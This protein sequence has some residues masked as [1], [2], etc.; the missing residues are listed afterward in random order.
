MQGGKVM[1]EE[2]L[3]IV[4]ERRKAK[5]K[6]GKRK[7]NAEFQRQQGKRR[8]PS[9]NKQTNKK[10]CKETKESNRIGKTR[11]LFKKR[12]IKGIFHMRVG[13]IKGRNS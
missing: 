6:G 11:D 4:E 12:D 1:C 8:K 13:T 10:Q 2:A 7:L 3:Q 5:G 9:S